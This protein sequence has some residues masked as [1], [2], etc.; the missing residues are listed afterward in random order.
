MAVSGKSVKINYQVAATRLLAGGIALAAGV[1][2]YDNTRHAALMG[3]NGLLTASML[4]AMPDLMMGL[5]L[6]KMSTA[7]ANH[8]VSRWIVAAFWF[9]L[10]TSVGSNE[11]AKWSVGWP[12][13]IEGLVLPVFVM[14]AVE[15]CKLASKT[16][17]RATTRR[18]AVKAPE[19]ASKR[20]SRAKGSAVRV[21]PVSV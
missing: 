7:A 15:V 17:R 8:R 3:H 16:T 20:P 12:G 6:L 2:S 9:G 19:V 4:G 5:S 10:L 18:A 13:R 1:A 14:L 21:Q 11:L